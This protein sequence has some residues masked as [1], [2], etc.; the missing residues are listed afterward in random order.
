MR[1]VY[2]WWSGCVVWMGLVGTGGSCSYR[3]TEHSS[4]VP[5]KMVTWIMLSGGV[6]P[7][8]WRRT[9]SFGRPAG[10]QHAHLGIATDRAGPSHSSWLGCCLRVLEVPGSK[11]RRGPVFWEAGATAP[12][13]NVHRRAESVEL[14]RALRATQL[15][16][17]GLSQSNQ[18]SII[19]SL[20]RRGHTSRD[21]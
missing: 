18:P 8:R 10:L 13:T 2:R 15:T 19:G 16:K 20:T 17:I 11:E 21:R 12:G 6:L 7:W 14:G 9:S 5:T 4:P 3:C 1:E